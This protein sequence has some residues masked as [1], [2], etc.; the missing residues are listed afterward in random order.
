MKLIHTRPHD[1]FCDN[2]PLISIAVRLKNER[3]FLPALIESLHLQTVNE[4][5]EYIFLDSGSTDGSVEYLREHADGIYAIL[6]GEFQFGRSCNQIVEKCRGR[7][8]VLLSAHV[9]LAQPDALDAAITLLNDNSK[10]AA[11]YFAQKTAGISG[12]DYSPYESLFLKKRFPVDDMWIRSDNF[13]VR[14]PISN[15]AAVIR[16]DLWKTCRFPEVAASEDVLWAKQIVAEGYEVAYIGSKQ[17]VHNHAESTE[18]VYR[19]VKINKVAQFGQ[20]AQPIRA[21]YYFFGIFAGLMWIE[22]AG[23]REA[24]RYARAHSKAYLV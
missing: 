18:T 22:R 6:P 19:R 21:C 13:P 5:C 15:A 9:V 20:R 7:F 3:P 4:A 17:I 24:F 23:L 2:T 12:V 14:A 10:L 8:V 1:R 11:V 16:K